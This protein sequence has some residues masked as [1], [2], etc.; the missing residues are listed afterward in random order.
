MGCA[1]T[2]KRILGSAGSHVCKSQIY[3]CDQA[4]AGIAEGGMPIRR[5]ER[6]E[7]LHGQRRPHVEAG[8]Y[9]VEKNAS[10]PHW[11]AGHFE[12]APV[13]VIIMV[14]LDGSVTVYRSYGAA[15]HK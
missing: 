4:G 14:N 8:E 1:F 13:D 6:I 10:M 2:R 9:F 3:C 5:G 7:H 12:I 15:E 11:Y